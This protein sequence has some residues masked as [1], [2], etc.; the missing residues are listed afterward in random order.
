MF[1]KSLTISVKTENWVHFS[2]LMIWEARLCWF[3]HV[4]R[5]WDSC[6]TYRIMHVPVRGHQ[7]RGRQQK[8]WM[9]NMK[10]GL[11]NLHLQPENTNNRDQWQWHFHVADPSTEEKI[12]NF[13][14]L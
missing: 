8:W 10:H 7:S 11:S 5:R 12:E 4:K 14:L 13:M 9:D 2:Q 6:I 1:I 3:G